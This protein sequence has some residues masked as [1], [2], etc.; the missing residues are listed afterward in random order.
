MAQPEF[1]SIEISEIPDVLRIA[2]EVRSTN[3][4]RVLSRNDEA[5][6]VVVP[7]SAARRPRSKRPGTKA[8]H[9]AFLAAA[10]GW[11][12]LIDPEEFKQNIAASRGSDR[13]PVNL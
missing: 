8:D 4:P 1:K 3:E 6:A 5:I 9:D 11:K 7:V 13:Y 12:D 10:G 2:E